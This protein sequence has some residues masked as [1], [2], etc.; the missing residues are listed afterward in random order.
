[1]LR[2][3]TSIL[4]ATCFFTPAQIT[5]SYSTYDTIV[6]WWKVY[7]YWELA[8][9][10]NRYLPKD[11][12]EK[13]AAYDR[14]IKA[15]YKKY[16]YEQDVDTKEL[17]RKISEIIQ[18]ARST[19]DSILSSNVHETT[20][21]YSHSGR[22]IKAY[23]KWTPRNWYN[24]ISSGIHGSYEYGTYE[25]ALLLVE[26]LE[27]TDATWWFII[28]SLNPDGLSEYENNGYKLNAYLEWRD[29]LRGVDL[30]RNFC[31]QNFKDTDFE[32]YGKPMKT[33]LWWC[34]S[35]I[36]TQVMVETLKRFYFK[37]AVSLHSQGE[38]LYIP[39]GSIHDTRVINFWKKLRNILPGYDFYPNTSSEILTAASIKKYEI[40]EWDSW[41]FTGTLDTFIYENYGIPIILLELK[42]HGEIEYR[43]RW[44]FDIDI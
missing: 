13:D 18:I 33:S 22:E 34:A 14:L 28:P 7:S 29:N 38:I 10:I 23:F 39:D 20:L 30:N 1:M 2:I 25:T 43:L 37:S 26:T 44:I 19:H 5:S 24:L 6:L 41:K 21:W 4:V 3:F 42:N 11:V 12:L 35:E 32:K 31:T 17:Y 15:V 16:V 36:E 8:G 27:N 9:V 40:D